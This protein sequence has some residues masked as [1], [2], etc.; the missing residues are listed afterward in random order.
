MPRT[1]KSLVRRFGS[2]DVIR[3][4]VEGA[5]VRVFDR[6]VPKLL[7]LLDGQVGVQQAHRENLELQNELLRMRIARERKGGT[8]K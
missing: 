4:S 5:V 3:S 1:T 8:A 2:G 6:G 7:D